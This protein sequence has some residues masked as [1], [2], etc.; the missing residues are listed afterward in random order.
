MQS[1]KR[2]STGLMVLALGVAATAA[3]AVLP[4]ESTSVET[5]PTPAGDHRTYIVDMEFNNMVGTRVVVVDPDQQKML[6]MISTAGAAPAVLSNDRKVVYTADMY[7]TRY[8]RGERFD[9]VTA[10]DASTLSPLWEVEIPPKRASTIVEPQAM[11]ISDDDRFVYV[12]NFTPAQSVSVVDTKTQEFVGEIEIS[13]CILNY[14]I[15][16]RKF[17]SLCGNGDL[18]VV[19]LND[20]GKE[21][22]RQYVPFFDPDKIE[23]IERAARGEGQVYYFVSVG[24]VVHPVDFSGDEPKVLPTWSLTEGL[25]SKASWGPG[26]WQLITVA[27]ALNRLYVLMHPDHDESKWE[28][29]SKTIWVY[30]LKTH[31]KV[32]TLKAPSFVW[33]ISATSDDKPLLLGANVSGGLEI[34]DLTA[35]KHIGSMEGLTKTSTTVLNY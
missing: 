34:F 27:P 16:D 5:L 9:M 3:Q 6:G 22:D 13:G 26:G 24:G 8:T 12:F 31:E 21:V 25:E 17:A 32:G 14:V 35:G 30:D 23:L 2:L 4:Q 29:P 20:E 10:W 7:H 11:T 33:S 28:N 1:I 15:G 18:L 19:T